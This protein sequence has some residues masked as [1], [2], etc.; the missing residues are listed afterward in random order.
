MVS[1]GMGLALFPAAYIASEFGKEP[2]LLLK[3]V[4]GVPME[5]LMYL[6]WRRGS[7]RNGHYENLLELAQMAVSDMHI[8]GVELEDT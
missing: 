1:M 4:E 7:S 6:V 2:D 5:R 8:E 3:K